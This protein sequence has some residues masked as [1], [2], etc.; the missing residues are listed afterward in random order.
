MELPDDVL[1]IIKDFSRPV[2]RPDWRQVH[3]YTNEQYYDDLYRRHIIR[4]TIRDTVTHIIC[5]RNIELNLYVT[6]KEMNMTLANRTV[7]P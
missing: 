3:R 7:W 5:I 2:T 1:A 4:F 6:N